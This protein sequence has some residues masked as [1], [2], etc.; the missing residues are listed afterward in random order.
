MSG[1][2]RSSVSRL[3]S[4]VMIASLAG[5]SL[6]SGGCGGSPPNEAVVKAVDKY[7]MAAE[8]QIFEPNEKTAE[9]V[10]LKVDAWKESEDDKELRKMAEKMGGKAAADRP[11][12]YEAKWTAELRFKSDIG[13]VLGEYNGR[14]VFETVAK[15][16]DTLA[17]SG[18]AEAAK[19]ST[20]WD[21]DAGPLDMV[22][23]LQRQLIGDPKKPMGMYQ[24][25]FDKARVVPGPR[26]LFDRNPYK[27]LVALSEL[28]APIVRGSDEEK[29]IAE[30]IQA[31]NKAAAE[32]AQQAAAAQQ[33]AFEERKRQQEQEL[34]EAQERAQAEALAQRQA[35]EAEVKKRERDAF[36]N[37]FSPLVAPLRDANGSFLGQAGGATTGVVLLKAEVDSESFAVKGTGID[38]RT[39]PISEF[40]FEGTVV[41][42]RSYVLRLSNDPEPITLRGAQAGSVLTDRRGM[43]LTAMSAAD[44]LRV[45][46]VAEHVRRLRGTQGIVLA[47][48]ALDAKAAAA[49]ETGMK[50]VPLAGTATLKGVPSSELAAIFAGDLARNDTFRLRSDQIALRL[51]R[52]T[53]GSALYVRGSA[54]ASAEMSIVL[55]GVHRI[56]VPAFGKLGGARVALPADLEI[57]DIRVDPLGSGGIRGIMLVK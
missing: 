52:P 40:T 33:A 39:L 11:T 19:L 27:P 57:V 32:K 50:T 44:R 51:D 37:R 1:L 24:P 42:Q 25:L 23:D 20:G 17:I 13:Q 45:D 26:G 34:R 30:Q 18:R 35:R 48:E 28:K 22:K 54:N 46:A 41:D 36:V 6:V 49:L 16:G 43:A 47:A 9:V 21:V 31:E 7:V 15:A 8:T 29:R 3:A 53:K 10:K 38:L 4:L 55:N 2:V 12:V 56:N 5:V 14:P